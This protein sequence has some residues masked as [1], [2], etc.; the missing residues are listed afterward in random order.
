MCVSVGNLEIWNEPDIRAEKLSVGKPQPFYL[1]LVN[2]LN[3]L[4]TD[5]GL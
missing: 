1:Q 3:L 4:D 2:L 5:Y